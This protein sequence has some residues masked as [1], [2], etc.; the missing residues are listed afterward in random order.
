MN[1]ILWE[2]FPVDADVSRA[3]V[4][5]GSEIVRKDSALGVIDGET[6]PCVEFIETANLFTHA[7]LGVRQKRAVIDVR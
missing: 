3:E 1:V 7:L 5:T 6:C 2:R 4:A